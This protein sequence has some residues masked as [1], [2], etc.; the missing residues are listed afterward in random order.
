MIAPCNHAMEM[1][2]VRVRKQYM[3]AD[4]FVP[5]TETTLNDLLLLLWRFG[6][7]SAIG[8]IY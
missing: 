6:F 2:K 5:V 7:G 8:F 1:P 4:S 3:H